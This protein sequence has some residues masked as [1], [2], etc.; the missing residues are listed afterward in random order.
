VVW[1]EPAVALQLL[2]NAGEGPQV[3]FKAQL[4][5]GND[6][7]ARRTML[8]TV[9]AFASGDGGTILFGVNDDGTVTGLDPATVD[10]QRD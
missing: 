1:E 9:A 3:E 6:N 2:I 4:P 7:A 8:K 5:D 10:R